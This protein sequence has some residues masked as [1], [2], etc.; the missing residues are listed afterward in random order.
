MAPP[1]HNATHCI[2]SAASDGYTRQRLDREQYQFP[3]IDPWEYEIGETVICTMNS[4]I[5]NTE[6]RIE[7]RYIN[8]HSR[9]WT[10]FMVDVT[11]EQRT[12]TCGEFYMKPLSKGGE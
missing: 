8:K 1:P 4:Q 2:S 3:D 10:Y 5:G 7:R 9:T 6:A 11:N 12:F